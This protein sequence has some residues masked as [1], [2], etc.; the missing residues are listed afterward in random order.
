MD[1]SQVEQTARQILISA[2]AG[3]GLVYL[4]VL[5]LSLIRRWRH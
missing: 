4:A 3:V 5:G 2:L 1:L